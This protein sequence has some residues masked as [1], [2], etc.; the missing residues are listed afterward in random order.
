L[1]YGING[2]RPEPKCGIKFK[3]MKALSQHEKLHGGKLKFN[4]RISGRCYRA[5]VKFKKK[6]C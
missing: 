6:L 2:I 4:F 1:K 3:T 5:K